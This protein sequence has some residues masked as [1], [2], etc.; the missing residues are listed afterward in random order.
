MMEPET[1]VFGRNNR[2]LQ[3]YRNFTQRL[4]V[5]I[6]HK[7][8]PQQLPVPVKNEARR[9]HFVEFPVVERRRPFHPKRAL[10]ERKRKP[11]TREDSHQY[12][13]ALKKAPHLRL[14]LT[15]INQSGHSIFLTQQQATLD[16]PRPSTEPDAWSM[17][18]KQGPGYEINYMPH[19]EY[20]HKKRRNPAVL[21]MSPRAALF[22]NSN[23]THNAG[24]LLNLYPPIRY[25]IRRNL[26]II[27]YSLANVYLYACPHAKPDP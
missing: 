20:S 7:N 12:S 26:L 8:A 9:L 23:L 13:A 24:S 21:L 17:I 16:R 25:S 6:L 11:D 5:A 15:L 18:K 3:I 4:L 14:P 10:P 2:F 1:R 22:A 19:G 27:K